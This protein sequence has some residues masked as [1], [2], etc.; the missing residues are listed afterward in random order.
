MKRLL[1]IA[2]V[3]LLTSTIASAQEVVSRI[4]RTFVSSPQPVITVR[5]QSLQRSFPVGVS[6]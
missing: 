5:Q 6:Y 4:F 2:M 3:V 1:L